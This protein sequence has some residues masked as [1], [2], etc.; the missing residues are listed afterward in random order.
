M[1][2][3]TT[4]R[5]AVVAEPAFGLLLDVDGPIASPVSRTVAI[6]SIGQDLAAMSNQGIPVIFN[7]GRSDDFIAQEVVPPLRA[8]GLRD[9]APVFTISEKGA[10]WAEV[11][12]HGLGEIH[13]DEELRLPTALAED[14]RALVAERFSGHVF[15]D[16]TKR[17]M[18]SVEQLVDV[19]NE[20]Y[21]MI[22]PEFDA[23]VAD[24]L[25][26]HRLDQVRIDPTII[27]TD[28]EHQRVG[29]DLGAARALEL[30]RERGITPQAWYTMGDSRTD[31]AMASWLHER[32]HQVSHVDVRP[33]D[34]IPETAHPVLTSDTG[35]IHDDAGAE[36]L[37]RWATSLG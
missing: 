27:S 13:L 9:G 34:G 4:P 31:Y 29:K 23:A 36:F 16:E 19:E 17:T 6:D 10:V 33:A 15:Y 20:D 32:G 12:P 26:K 3:S 18:I 2:V 8:S 11:T 7:T 25:E 1:T 30:L 14:V 22:Q 24:L 35:A 5:P 21:L 37:R 28:V